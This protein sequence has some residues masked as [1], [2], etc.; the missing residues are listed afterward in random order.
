MPDGLN[1]QHA[2]R[3]PRKALKAEFRRGLTVASVFIVCIV[4]YFLPVDVSYSVDT[5][6]QIW[7]A[8]E[9]QLV[10]DPA[11]RLSGALYD[12][13]NGVTESYSV[14]QFEREDAMDFRLRPD[15]LQAGYVAEGDTI[16]EI[17]S[18]VL[19]RQLAGFGQVIDGR[20]DR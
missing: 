19:N 9:W 20:H 1:G 18:T 3:L 14:T 8:R 17:N 15:A 6:G 12:R 2:H 13:I 7:P 10:R 4:V 5:V 11:G 16:G